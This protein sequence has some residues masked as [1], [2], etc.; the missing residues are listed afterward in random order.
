MAVQDRNDNPAG[1]NYAAPT[2]PAYHNPYLHQNPWAG[3]FLWIYTIYPSALS[4]LRVLSLNIQLQSLP[5]ISYRYLSVKI[6][7]HSVH[8][9]PTVRGMLHVSLNYK[10]YGIQHI[11]FEKGIRFC[12][13][14]LYAGKAKDYNGL[15]IRVQW[16]SSKFSRAVI[17]L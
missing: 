10:I 5:P 2:S 9:S 3:S 1:I 14:P 6:R 16:A 12:Y 4:A 8:H 15:F 7:N 17:C 13:L 11:S